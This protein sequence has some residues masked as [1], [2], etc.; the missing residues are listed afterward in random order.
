[1]NNLIDDV[2]AEFADG[3][4]DLRALHSALAEVLPEVA[5][6]LYGDN[7]AVVPPSQSRHSDDILDQLQERTAKG[8]SFSSLRLLGN[9]WIHGL[10]VA[11]YHTLL[12]LQAEGLDEDLSRN[13]PLATLYQ[14]SVKL[15]MLRCQYQEAL[16]ENEQLTR[17]MQVVSSK[18]TKLLD[19]NHQ[20]FLLIQEKEKDYAKKLESE[21]ARQTKQL[22]E[23]N[24]SLEAASRLKSEFLANMSHELRTPMNA[25][26]GFS[27]LLQET[28]LTPEQR[29]FTETIGKA[30]LSLLVLINDILDLAKIEAGKLELDPAPFQLMDLMKNVEAMFRSQALRKEIKLIYQVDPSLPGSIIGDENRLRQIFVNLV[31]N[32]MKFT[33]RGQIVIK[34]DKV[35]EDEQQVKLRFAVSDTGIGIPPDRQKAIFEKFTQADGSTTRKF[36]GT[37]LGLA[38]TSQLVSMMHGEIEL[39]SAENKGS[40]FSFVISLQKDIAPADS[41]LRSGAPVAKS[42]AAGEKG[43]PTQQRIED[44]PVKGDLKVLV[45]EDNLVNQRLVTLLLKKADCQA[46]IAGDGLQALEMLKEHQYDFVLMDVQMPN[47][48]GH[49]ATRRIREIEASADKDE[50]AAFAG[51]EKPLYVVGL[52]AHARKEDERRCYDAGMDGFLSKPII[53]DK[54]VDLIEKVR[55]QKI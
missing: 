26:I 11:D 1:M 48:D 42:D 19:D 14:N 47:M 30:S 50:Y 28:D 9:R 16:I 13:I 27:G 41:L 43:K 34:A 22:R 32:A 21:I 4:E 36:G 39:E 31:G 7:G 33:G 17:R 10:Q 2:F 45:V 54:L 35:Q 15:A 12:V 55:S 3:D 52:T 40:T 23:A 38:I 5:V 6:T 25:I 46:D 44:A 37:G 8:E 49:T 51:R 29:E 24:A 20:Q 18:H 53:R